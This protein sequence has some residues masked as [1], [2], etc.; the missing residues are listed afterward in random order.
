MSAREMRIRVLM[1]ALD[2][3]SGPVKKLAQAASK[4]SR[5]IKEQTAEIK[6]LQKAQ[7]KLESYRAVR[8]ELGAS[9]KA[10]RDARSHVAKLR[11]EYS[12]LERPTRAQ[13]TALNAATRAADKAQLKFKLQ[14][15]RLKT[16]RN[17]FRDAGASV[18]DLGRYEDQLKS[19][20]S[21]TTREIEQQ[22]AALEKLRKHQQRAHAAQ[23]K[24]NTIN[25]RAGNLASFGAGA[26]AAGAA[27]SAPFVI[28]ARDAMNY[29]SAL[30]DIRQ[31]AGLARDAQAEL[32][33]EIRRNAQAANLFPEEMQAI[34]DGLTGRGQELG[35]AR[36]NAPLIGRASTAFK[37]D[38]EAGAQATDA[39]LDNM[40]VATRR[41]LDI[42][43]YGDQVGAVGFGK[44]AEG[45]PNLTAG[46]RKLGAVGD[47][48]FAD[49]VAAQ[50]MAAKAAGSPEEAINNIN[51]L[52]DKARSPETANA[53]KKMGVDLFKEM[54]ALEAA[55]RTPLEAITELTN[56]TL[57]GD[58]KRLGYLFGDKQARDGITALIQNFDQYKKIRDDALN[59]DGLVDSA[60]DDRMLDAAEKMKALQIAAKDASIELGDSVKPAIADVAAVLT[61]MV[62]GFGKFAKEHPNLMKVVGVFALLVT[63]A[64]VLALAAAAIL[65]PFAMLVVVAG[66]ISIPF[67]LVGAAIMAAVAVVAV[68]I[69]Q[70]VTHWDGIIAWFNSLPAKFEVIGKA[71]MQ[72]LTNGMMMMLSP[73]TAVVHLISKL[74][75]DGMKKKLGI[76]SPSRVFAKLGGY[77]MDG[78]ALGLQEGERRPL[79]RMHG[80][81][82]A[83][84]AAAGMGFS[85]PAFGGGFNFHSPPAV[86]QGRG[87]S[88]PAPNIPI[89]VHASPGMDEKQLARLIAEEVRKIMAGA[90]RS[91]LRAYANDSDGD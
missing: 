80:T 33:D 29:E 11:A 15:D 19:K 61:P 40:G 18:R 62:E 68:G 77:A 43:A 48:A 44:M 31:K 75:P 8:S 4:T 35:L 12:A 90:D 16:L 38:P 25:N 46:Y 30:T 41:A 52:I 50:Q 6:A 1:S 67:L 64:G 66:A 69:H 78:L 3:A 83:L 73:L 57:K 85:G 10:Y 55:G 23:A 72:G 71:I 88:A 58:T 7:G 82:A 76:H 79:A 59:S 91:R 9:A 74:L 81:A 17:E 36:Q 87:S 24:A 89:T 63:V 32:G 26:T 60:F 5:A 45:L 37:A 54:D 86:A 14:A 27:M 20:I 21:G 42:M 51:N 34:L 84:T 28:G 53:F 65:A 2:G 56:K 13:T 39:A 22:E 70:I 49:L 47:R